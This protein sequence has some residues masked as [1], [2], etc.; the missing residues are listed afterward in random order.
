MSNSGGV[1]AELGPASGQPKCAYSS[2]RGTCKQHALAGETYCQAHGCP[3]PGCS[4]AKSSRDA[5]CGKCTVVG[6][7]IYADLAPTEYRME[8]CAYSSARGTCKQN[9]LEG[10]KYCAAHGCG[11]PGCTNPKSSRDA[12]CGK[13]TGDNQGGSAQQPPAVPVHAKPAAPSTS[14]PPS[15]SSSGE[16]AVTLSPPFGM[17]LNGTP[18]TGVFILGFTAT[19]PAKATALAVGMMIVEVSGSNVRGKAKPGVIALLKQ[20][21]GPTSLKFVQD[22]AAYQQYQASLQQYEAADKAAQN[23]AQNTKQGA[24]C[25]GASSSSSSGGLQVTITKPLGLR[26]YGD[27]SSGVFVKNVEP[28]MAAAGAG[29]HTGLKIA[30]VNGTNVLGQD[31]PFVMQLLKAAVAELSLAFL[32][33]DAG[34][35]KFLQVSGQAPGQNPNVVTVVVAPP[36]GIR[37]HGSPES[38]VFVKNVQPG[39]NSDVAGVQAGLRVA[40]INNVSCSGRDRKEVIDLMKAASG[41]TP[42]QFIKDPDG[43]NKYLASLQAFAAG[44][45]YG[46]GLPEPS[47]YVPP[48]V[49]HNLAWSLVQNAPGLPETTPHAL[50]PQASPEKSKA[51]RQT[52]QLKR[53]MTALTRKSVLGKFMEEQA[54][55]AVIEPDYTSWELLFGSTRVKDPVRDRLRRY[56]YLALFLGECAFFLPQ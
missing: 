15:S 35:R 18:D 12:N 17:R 47:G 25:G 40:A 45:S 56:A 22:P 14:P 2:A 16:M 50:N 54:R 28:G 48:E 44:P 42:L 24:K 4:N 49:S 19:S 43:H 36:F 1:Y 5:D 10:K 20:A 39:S 8:K 31:K 41:P 27:A 52:I 53:V 51:W 13:C 3:K 6:G 21:S 11:L 29:V 33:D 34:H 55:I 7:G 32:S 23:A 38:G 46:L 37:L 9:A 26:L 30:S